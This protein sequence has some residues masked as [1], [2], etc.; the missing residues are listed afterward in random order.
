MATYYVCNE[1]GDWW[2]MDTDTDAGHTLF[3]ICEDDLKKVVASEYPNEDLEPSD[4]DKLDRLI[5]RE[6]NALEVSF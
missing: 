4:I 3:A 6:G 2:T 5:I 1:N